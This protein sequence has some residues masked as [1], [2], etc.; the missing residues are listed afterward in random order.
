MKVTALAAIGGL[1]TAAV[2]GVAA[3]QMPGPPG[4]GMR[5]PMPDI[6]AILGLDPERAAQV[7]AILRSAREK[8]REA[9]EQ[10]GPPGDETTRAAMQAAMEAIRAQT[11]ELLAA[12][13]TAEE[14]AKLRDALPPPPSRGPRQW[15]RG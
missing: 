10:L 11:D 12:V 15:K 7:A 9:H 4:G 5:G 13:L 8:I 6:A 1:V 2:I 3:A 14:L